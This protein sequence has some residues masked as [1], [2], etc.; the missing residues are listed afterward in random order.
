MDSLRAFDE[1]S[2]Y[3]ASGDVEDAIEAPPEIGI[4]ERRMH[5][6]AYNYWVG[7]LD[8]RP[9]PNISELD[10]RTI[11]D[12]GPHSVLLDFSEG[13][14]DPK[15]SWLGHALREECD[16][17]GDIRRISD[18]PKRSLLSRLTDHYMQIIANQAPI[19]F[20]AEFMGQRGRNTMYRGILMPFSSSGESI[21]FIYG[22]I[23]WKEV[24]DPATTAGIA[25]QARSLLAAAP[26]A[27]SSPVWADGPNAEVP[28]PEP[29]PEPS[30]APAWDEP[31]L[32]FEAGLA[33]RLCAAR[34]SAEAATGA[35]A[36]SRG[37]LYRALG[38]AYDFALAAEA[39]PGDYAE[40]LEDAGIKA[41]AR[42]PMTAVAK[43]VFGVRCDK[44]R[45]TEFA[46]VLSFARREALPMGGLCPRLEATEGGLKALV[47]AERKAR[48]PEPRPDSGADLGDAARAALR[49][50][51]PL[52]HVA[53]E[54]GEE[55]FVLLVG[56][57]DE[58]GGVAVVCAVA[59]PALLERA[60]RKAATR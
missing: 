56:R 11:D 8:G 45:L 53:I 40:M 4:D 22:V 25:E 3:A 21:D 1:D 55:E 10:P 31:A 29:E 44:A 47:A 6:R 15:V 43:L 23:N 49:A 12:F 57:R 48:R 58:V 2:A 38:Q 35:E 39:E 52:G 16:L 7:L 42:A 26:A 18:V 32:P 34:E 50:A 17:L 24:A 14:D 19:G 27:A 33:D 9:Y 30:E 13:G 37:A 54:A 46:A 5:V 41:Q 60:I 51:R 59:D 36:R 28:A 20:E